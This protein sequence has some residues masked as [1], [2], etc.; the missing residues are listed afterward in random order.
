MIS[1]NY[2][3]SPGQLGN[4]MFKYAA[5][6]GIANHLQKDFLMPP[7]YQI[8]NNK[9]IFR[10]LNKF[11]FIDKRNHANHLLFKYFQMNSVTGNN[12]GY[13]DFN[14]SISE[15]NYV[16]DSLFFESK[17][18]FFDIYGYFQTYKY[19][20]N[21]SDLISSDFLFK[22]KIINKT[23]QI[24]DKLDDPISIHI[25]RGDYLTNPNHSSLPISY[26]I[27]AMQ[28]FGMDNQYLVFSDD[29][30]W[31]QEVDIF[32]GENI[33]FAENFTMQ[34]EELD[35][36]LMSL[37]KRHIIANSTFSWW[38]AWL[39]DPKKVITPSEWFKGTPYSDYDTSDLIPSGWLKIDN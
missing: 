9:L 10:L 26:Y 30:K 32:R 3:A 34:K 39:S 23:N 29:P 8:L 27:N 18:S 36:S 5:L 20:E 13:S 19:F 1:F 37:C 6:R 33:V 21:I 28:E 38:G 2:L 12:I 7:A 31:C 35:L 4:Q 17:D 24:I 22:K 15:E 11:N 16:F 25:R 14:N